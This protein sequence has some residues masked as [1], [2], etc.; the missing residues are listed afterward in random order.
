L[1]RHITLAEYAAPA[2]SGMV[3]S[4]PVSYDEEEAEAAEGRRRSM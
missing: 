1:C 4:I 2:S 3:M